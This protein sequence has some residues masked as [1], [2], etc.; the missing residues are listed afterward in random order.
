M[1]VT[2]LKTFMICTVFV[3]TLSMLFMLHYSG[4]A[5]RSHTELYQNKSYYVGSST[6]K[7]GWMN[8]NNTSQRDKLNSSLDPHMYT[9]DSSPSKSSFAPETNR[10]WTTDRDKP[11]KES[12]QQVIT[13]RNVQK[14]TKPSST[15]SSESHQAKELCPS[16]SKQGLYIHTCMLYL[17][18]QGKRWQHKL[19]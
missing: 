11:I 5:T 15:T 3:G 13:K 19:M 10:N 18:K 6:I 14:E 2:R 7:R 4:A 8:V 1:G 16:G 12:T 17:I 9:P